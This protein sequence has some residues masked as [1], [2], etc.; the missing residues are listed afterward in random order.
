M[1]GQDGPGLG[2]DFS[3]NFFRV[4]LEGVAIDIYEDGHGACSQDGGYSSDKGV[5]RYQYFITCSYVQ[6]YQRCYQGVGAVDQGKTTLRADCFCP[7]C[8]KFTYDS[9]SGPDAAS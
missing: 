6:L 7:L 2:S 4:D 8:F 1:N 3:F 5:R 9:C